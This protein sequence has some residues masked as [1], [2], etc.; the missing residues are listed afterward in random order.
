M[1][2]LGNPL[3]SLDAFCQGLAMRLQD[4]VLLSDILTELLDLLLELLWIRG[5]MVGEA[6]DLCFELRQLSM[7]FSN[8]RRELLCPLLCVFRA[9]GC[10]GKQ[11]L[12]S[13]FNALVQFQ[14]NLLHLIESKEVF[15]FL[16][17]L[18]TRSL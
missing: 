13:C 12:E 17:L 14:K 5:S 8:F 4:F 16:S 18:Y 15:F 2:V 10:G 7:D 11:V 3:E 6:V 9:P 1:V